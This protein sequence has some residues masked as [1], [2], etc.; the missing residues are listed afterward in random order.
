MLTQAK[1]VWM[2]VRVTL[3][4]FKTARVVCPNQCLMM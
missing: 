4:L 1:L 2:P 3:I